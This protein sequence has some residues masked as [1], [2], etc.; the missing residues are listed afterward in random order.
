MCKTKKR[1]LWRLIEL[2]AQVIIFKEG[3]YLLRCIFGN[4]SFSF[5]TALMTLVPNN[6]FVILYS[7]IFI[8]SPYINLM[9]D[10]LS[11]GS[12][13]KLVVLMFLIFSVYTTAV[14]VIGEFLDFE[15]VGLSPIGM[16]GSEYGYSIVNFVLMYMIGAYIKKETPKC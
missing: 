16:Y 11:D 6:Y 14:D 15:W 3:I 12:F 13:R 5:K 8:M 1:N 4:T 2:F 10:N 7:V 9:I